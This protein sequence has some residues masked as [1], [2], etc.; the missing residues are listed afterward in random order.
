MVRPGGK[1][2]WGIVAALGLAAC[3]HN[4]PDLP[5]RTDF[6]GIPVTGDRSL[7]ASLER[8]YALLPAVDRAYF[9]A[10]KPGRI[11][12]VDQGSGVLHTRPAE[13]RLARPTIYFSRTWLA[14]TLVHEACHIHL[15]DAGLAPLDEE[16]RCLQRQLATASAIHA[17][18]REQ[19][20]IARADGTHIRTLP[21]AQDW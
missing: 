15:A 21:A 20:H 13:L 12:L 14:S 18:E 5:R 2:L 3:V 10:N 9:A 6:I 1:C 4:V 11:V 19:R 7:L 17:P 16:R 8:A